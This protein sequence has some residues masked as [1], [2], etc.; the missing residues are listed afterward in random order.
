MKREN[1]EALK[2]H[3]KLIDKIATS[4]FDD[5]NWD[6]T[7][8]IRKLE[9]HELSNF[10]NRENDCNIFDIETIHAFME[11]RLEHNNM[12]LII[13]GEVHRSR[14]SIDGDLTNYKSTD[15]YRLTFYTN[16]GFEIDNDYIHEANP[17]IQN[18]GHRITRELAILHDLL[19]CNGLNS[20]RF[21]ELS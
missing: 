1:I 5:A 4:F 21:K 12:I 16:N 3:C 13:E 18:N 19:P 10:D 17:F 7:A 2:S 14:P 9:F 11:I 8:G 15:N 6:A 20:K